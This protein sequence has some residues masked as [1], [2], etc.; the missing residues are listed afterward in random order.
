MGD[1]NLEIG[2]N[3]PDRA[4]D[5][6]TNLVRIDVENASDERGLP[7]TRISDENDAKPWAFC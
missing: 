4:P 7:Y 6:G 5:D 1:I 3:F 2:L